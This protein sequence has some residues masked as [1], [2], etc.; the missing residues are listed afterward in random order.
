MDGSD[1]NAAVPFLE[2]ARQPNLPPPPSRP[3]SA[4]RV[5][6]STSR[7]PLAVDV[8]SPSASPRSSPQQRLSLVLTDLRALLLRLHSDES[9]VVDS[10]ALRQQLSAIVQQAQR[11]DCGSA[12]IPSPTTAFT[13]ASPTALSLPLSARSASTSQSSSPRSE[14]SA[15]PYPAVLSPHSASTATPLTTPSS[16]ES[17]ATSAQARLAPLDTSHS[18]ASTLPFHHPI[19]DSRAAALSALST[20]SASHTPASSPATTPTA[21]ASGGATPSSPS[22]LQHVSKSP[23]R[24]LYV[25]VQQQYTVTRRQAKRMTS[26][27]REK[28][29]PVP[30]RIM[31]TVPLAGG[32]MKADPYAC[33]YLVAR[34]VCQLIH[35]RQG[36]VSKVIHDFL[37]SERSRIP[38]LCQRSTGAGCTQ[39]LTVLTM[40]GVR[41]LL[42]NSQSPLAPHVLKWISEQVDALVRD[43][44]KGSGGG[45]ATTGVDDRALKQLLKG[46]G[47][48]LEGERR[49]ER[50]RERTGVADLHEQQDE[51]D[52]VGGGVADKRARSDR[53]VAEPVGSAFTDFTAAAVTPRQLQQAQSAQ[54]LFSTAAA[55]P[56]LPWLSAPSML[57]AGSS[58]QQLMLDAQQRELAAHMQAV[59][60]RVRENEQLLLLHQQRQHQQQQQQQQQHQALNSAFPALLPQPSSLP[61]PLPA[62]VRPFLS[63]LDSPS[64]AGPGF[65]QSL[66]HAQLLAAY[67]QQQHAAAAPLGPSQPLQQ[68]GSS[69]GSVF[70]PPHSA[71]S[72]SVAVPGALGGLLSA[73]AAVP[74]KPLPQTFTPLTLPIGAG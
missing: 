41:R 4:V 51:D 72:L 47:M 17:S 35:L 67:Q 25:K 1:S 16:S 61:P 6:D 37:P 30:V 34:D 7:L 24:V 32:G 11:S 13:L 21:A 59:Q 14:S 42:N 9:S 23:L 31:G 19:T 66:L 8:T 68:S 36:S 73:E 18:T 12:S 56:K 5:I 58:Y 15:A 50:K 3:S 65:S 38:I 45:A 33:L 48:V 39:V 43:G 20:L 46:S 2:A 70:L 53:S 26:E 40:D 57:A 69:G 63:P 62:S 55:P 49:R 54:Q 29:V 52:S 10:A 60:A 22:L 64:A 74:F 28:L 71:S 44:G 27:E